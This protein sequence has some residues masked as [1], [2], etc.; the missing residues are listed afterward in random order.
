MGD[1]RLYNTR[2]RKT[3]T[4]KPLRGRD[5]R[6]YVCGL[7][8]SAEAHLGHARSFLFFDL[9]RR[10][11]EHS[12]YD[13]TYVQN[14]TD[15]DDR[16]INRA[17]ETGEDWHEIVMGFYRSFKASMKKLSVRDPDVE[18]YATKYIAQIQAMILELLKC[19]HAYVSQDG[20]YYR[21]STFPA[22][23][24][25]SNRNIEELEAGARIEVD[26]HK[27]NP[28]DF[29][30]WKFAKPGEPFWTFEGYGEGRPGWHIE[31]SAMSKT[32]LDPDG[33]GFDIH[34]GGADLIFPHHENEIAQSEPLMGHPPM[35]NFWVH[36]GLLNFDGR[37]MSKSLGNFEPLSDLVARHDP[38]A[39]RLTFLSTGY[40]KVMNFTDESLAA[41]M[42]TLDRL[43]KT[44]R[45][46][47]PFDPVLPKRDE[48][49]LL[50]KMEA[51]LSD[52]MNTSVALAELLQWAVVENAGGRCEFERALW[53]LGLEPNE[54][55]L[56][57]AEALLPV[58]LL[59]RLR[60]E[61]GTEIPFNGE[62]PEQALEN[63]INVRREAR[64]RKDFAASDRLRDALMRCGI[65][66][67]D[68]KEGTSWT[69]LS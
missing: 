30:L 3:E 59:E 58:D 50:P 45:R 38:Q 25:L 48:Q 13:V 5:V 69:V 4:F 8:P 37:K 12:G 20:I 42:M 21:V 44:Y 15:I 2:T 52:D 46:L 31:C 22:Y 17:R 11:L 24:K 23:G 33:M 64:E 40:S 41:S 16:S 27:E 10:F 55:W 19:G 6:I 66:I 53:L 56:K 57:E 29:A 60:A 14:V 67:K 28:L 18:P 65:A 51:A 36:G 7:T 34:G 35:A 1:L 43:K 62:T 9:L 47:V 49:T 68:S 26:E 54:E 39:I 63:V 32:L 61:L